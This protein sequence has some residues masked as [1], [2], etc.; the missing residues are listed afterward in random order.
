MSYGIDE[1]E[2]ISE[3][4]AANNISRKYIKLLSKIVDIEK[5]FKSNSKDTSYWKGVR[6]TL[7]T[8]EEVIKG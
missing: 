8:I 6:D 7:D 2:L 4:D 1:K 5:S 3:L